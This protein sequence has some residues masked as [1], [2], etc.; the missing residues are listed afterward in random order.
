MIDDDIRRLRSLAADL[1]GHYILG[2]DGEPQR[3][4]LLTWAQWFEANQATGARIVLR[5][6]VA[7]AS[8][9]RPCSSGSITP[10]WAARRSCGRR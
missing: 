8:M 6:T 4:D 3:V 7:P 5:E 9:S 1:P 2:E 10:S